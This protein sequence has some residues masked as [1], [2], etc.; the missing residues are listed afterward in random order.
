MNNQNKQ[1]YN[2]GIKAADMWK[3]LKNVLST[4]DRRCVHWASNHNAPKWVGR[5]PLVAAI[6]ASFTGMIAGGFV[7]ALII[8]FMWAIAFILQNA[9]FSN[10]QV[11]SSSDD[12]LN[13]DDD[14]YRNGPD[15]YGYYMDGFRID[16]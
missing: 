12:E 15:G 16:N 11:S 14:G 9:D 7:I 2:R 10:M 6:L 13:F 1:A 4:W 8:G 5:I 3:K